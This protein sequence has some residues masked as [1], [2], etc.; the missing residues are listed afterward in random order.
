MAPHLAANQKNESTATAES[1]RGM[2]V[3][4][5]EFQL[6]FGNVR[7]WTAPE[8]YKDVHGVRRRFE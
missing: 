3:T 2:F 5:T 8:C 6:I 1:G 7:N 4:N